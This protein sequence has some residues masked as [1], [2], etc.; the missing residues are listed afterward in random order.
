MADVDEIL[1]SKLWARPQTLGSILVLIRRCRGVVLWLL[2]GLLWL[3][4]LSLGT[5]ISRVAAQDRSKR[6]VVRRRVVVGAR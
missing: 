1:S 2:R 6:V 4:M 5:V 3:L